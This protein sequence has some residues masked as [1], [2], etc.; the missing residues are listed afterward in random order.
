MAFHAGHKIKEATA[1]LLAVVS[2]AQSLGLPVGWR[3]F[4]YCMSDRPATEGG[5][6]A[7]GDWKGASFYEK[8]V[9]ALRWVVLTTVAGVLIGLGGPFW[10]KVFSSLSQVA[11]VLRAFGLGAGKPSRAEDAPKVAAMDET[12]KPPN[13]A[14]AFRVAAEVYD[15]TADYLSARPVSDVQ[16][17]AVDRQ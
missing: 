4:P 16:K 8:I 5:Y 12:A 10:F 14:A 11:Q 1:G 9:A 7:C 17:P 3:Y 2:A 6:L 15:R 13:V